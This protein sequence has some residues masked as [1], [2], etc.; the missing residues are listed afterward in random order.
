MRSV[1]GKHITVTIYTNLLGKPIV[2]KNYPLVELE[3]DVNTRRP[4]T[5]RTYDVIPFT[6]MEFEQDEAKRTQYSEDIS[7]LW[8][9]WYGMNDEQKAALVTEKKQQAV[10]WFSHELSVDDLINLVIR[11]K[12]AMADPSGR[13]PNDPEYSGREINEEADPICDVLVITDR[14]KLLG[15]DKEVKDNLDRLQKY[16]KLLILPDE[17]ADI[18]DQLAIDAHTTKTR[19]SQSSLSLDD[20]IKNGEFEKYLKLNQFKLEEAIHDY[21]VQETRADIQKKIILL[22]SPDRIVQTVLWILKAAQKPEKLSLAA[23]YVNY[24]EAVHKVLRSM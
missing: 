15:T 24:R 7:P 22:D 20:F 5:E 23:T 13:N 9:Q 12:Q 18:M 8:Q 21:I 4:R 17:I 19:M 2:R 14:N 10:V 16:F 1:N 3:S 11:R 6:Y